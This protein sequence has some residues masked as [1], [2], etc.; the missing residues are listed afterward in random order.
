[1]EKAKRSSGELVRRRTAPR[2]LSFALSELEERLRPAT[3]LAEVQAA[4]PEAA[5]GRP[6]T[7]LRQTA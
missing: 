7:K 4:W 3:V 2:P 6:L 5:G 1:M